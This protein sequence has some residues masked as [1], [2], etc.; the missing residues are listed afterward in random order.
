MGLMQLMPST[1]RGL[2]VDNPFDPRE[3]VDAG[4]RHL[5]GLLNSYNGNVRLSLAA[6]N[7]GAGA[8]A[9]YGNVVPPYRETQQYVE[10]ITSLYGHGSSRSDGSPSFA[11]TPREIKAPPAR[12]T[13]NERG[14]LTLSNND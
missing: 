5:K 6:Y 13:R 9:K 1:A 8:V 7:A 14:I 3:N 11:S 2:G 4:V 10:R 12:M